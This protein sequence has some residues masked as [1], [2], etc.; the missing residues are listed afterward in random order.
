MRK[1]SPLGCIFE[2]DMEYPGRLHD[3][4]S[5]FLFLPE[6]K[7]PP[8]GKH[9]KLVTTLE[10]KE[11]YVIHYLALQQAIANGFKL[12][13]VHGVLHF[14]Q[15]PFLKPY[16][17]LNTDMRKK[18]SNNFDKDFFKLMNNAVYGKTMENVRK[19]MNG[20]ECAQSLHMQ[21]ITRFTVRLHHPEKFPP[22]TSK[23]VT[24]KIPGHMHANNTF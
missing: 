5:N 2:V 11:H 16:I 20:P 13:K 6:N 9:S 1:D 19:R 7:V 22:G 24:T 3:S 18:A 8:G 15:S 12:T 17:E 14:D 23:V 10:T 4:H 21:G